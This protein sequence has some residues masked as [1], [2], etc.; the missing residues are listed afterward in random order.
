L[1]LL[2][3]V[4]LETCSFTF[5]L[6]QVP[7]ATTPAETTLG[8][9]HVLGLE[10]VRRGAK[11][12]LTI[13]T[14]TLQFRS[15]VAKA[16]VKISSIRDVFTGEDSKAAVGGRVGTVAKIAA[17]Y[18]SG[19]VISLFR[20]KIDSLALDYQDANG[21]FHGVIFTLPQGQGAALKKQ[22]IAEGAHASIPSSEAAKTPEG[23]EDKKP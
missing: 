19:R 12:T 14:G 5:V 8:V 11:G 7:P 15:G 4:A 20:E 17:P 18:G 23:K 21:G 10:N 13:Q 6:G 2:A 16:E 22:L 1:S 9:V 3:W